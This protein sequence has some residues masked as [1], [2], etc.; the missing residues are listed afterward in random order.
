MIITI[1]TIKIIIEIPILKIILVIM[2]QKELLQLFRVLNSYHFKSRRLG[3]NRSSRNMFSDETDNPSSG[4][5]TVT[6][7]KL[8]SRLFSVNLGTS[9]ASVILPQAW[10]S[11]VIAILPQVIVSLS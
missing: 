5:F 2:K 11:M 7:D 6:Q 1:I 3:D 8:S 9:V 10:T 4:K